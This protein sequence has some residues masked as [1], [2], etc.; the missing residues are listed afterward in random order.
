MDENQFA[1][2]TKAMGREVTRRGTIARLFGGLVAAVAG[3]S[4]AA[5][6]L[7]AKRKA[8]KGGKAKKKGRKGGNGSGVAKA[9]L[10]VCTPET[11]PPDQSNIPQAQDSVCNGSSASQLSNQVNEVCPCL[12]FDFGFKYDT[13]NGGS[14]TC[15]KY[16]SGGDLIQCTAARC[17][18]DPNAEDCC[19]GCTAD[20]TLTPVD[21]VYNPDTDYLN[22]ESTGCAKVGAVVM[23]TATVNNLYNYSG[24]KTSDTC[25]YASTGSPATNDLKIKDLSHVIFCYDYAL[26]VSKTANTEYTRTWPW[27]VAKTCPADQEWSENQ[28]DTLTYTVTPS[29]GTP[30]DSGFTV[31][32]QITIENC[33]AVDATI[34]SITDEVAP[35][36]AAVVVC[37]DT[38]KGTLPAGE[39]LTCQYS[40]TLATKTDGT[41]TATVT[42]SGTVGGGT[43]TKDY[44]FGQPTTKVDECVTLSDP[45]CTLADTEVC[46]GDTLGLIICTQTYGP[47]NLDCGDNTISNTVTVETSAEEDPS[48]TCSFKITV[49][50]QNGCTLTQGYWKTH[51]EYGPA[52]KR[53]ATWDK[54]GAKGE[55]T[56]FFLSG[57]TWYEVLWTSPAGNAYYNLA[58]QYIAAKLNILGGAS[59]TPAVDAA[60]TG[61][62][63]WFS[64]KTPGATLTKAQR[65]QLLAWAATLDQYNNGLIGPGHCS[66]QD[67]TTVVRA[68]AE[69]VGKQRRKKRGKGRGHGKK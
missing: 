45:N 7:D 12:G 47:D 5:Q 62:E 4:L 11:N 67:T 27:S 65:Q 32:G 24:E 42:T 56:I 48:A 2:I 52:K 23:K 37:P 36:N 35:G 44:A 30:A 28:T 16:D 49:D 29:V 38:F 61:A 54:V 60:I 33:A 57:K 8:K 53:D 39:T 34:T 21:F 55:D 15:V 10:E 50:C 58:H 64:T 31:K 9:A 51:S 17:N 69:R 59:S 20:G 43:A 19:A 25:L 6:E 3:T 22:W 1:A 66:E 40:A 26:K 14:Y 63:G 68:A 18:V 46:A 13:G 41:N